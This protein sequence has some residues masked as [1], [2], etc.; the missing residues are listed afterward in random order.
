MWS[1]TRNKTSAFSNAS[2]RKMWYPSSSLCSHTGVVEKGTHM[3]MKSAFA[4]WRGT[5]P[6]GQQESRDMSR[7][8]EP[9]VRISTMCFFL[10]FLS[11]SVSHH[12]SFL[13]KSDEVAERWK[14]PDEK[15]HWE[16]EFKKKEKKKKA[17]TEGI[18]VLC[19]SFPFEL[20]GNIIVFHFLVL[21]SFSSSPC[22]FSRGH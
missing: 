13:L 9:L 20:C 4:T 10:S 11:L 2:Q 1:C 12:G 14:K 22:H 5:V 19:L 6:C 21:L 16:N 17:A 3:L 15:K 7:H 18:I 8:K